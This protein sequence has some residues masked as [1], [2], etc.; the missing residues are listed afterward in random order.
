MFFVARACPN[1]SYSGARAAVDATSPPA[2]AALCFHQRRHLRIFFAPRCCSRPPPSP[3]PT[4]FKLCGPPTGLTNYGI[5]PKGTPLLASHVDMG[6]MQSGWHSGKI[7]SSCAPRGLVLCV[8]EGRRAGGEGG[9]EWA[10]AI[11]CVMPRTS[12]ATQ[13]TPY[14][15]PAQLAPV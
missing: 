14:F 9:N 10:C 7:F 5:I 4:P 13:T 12:H 15:A 2:A 1:G 11:M 6:G 3:L 8:W